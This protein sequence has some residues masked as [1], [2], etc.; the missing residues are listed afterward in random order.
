[1]RTNESSYACS[2][3]II[4]NSRFTSYS[5][6]SNKGPSKKGTASHKGHFVKSSYPYILNLQ[7][8]DI[9]S[10]METMVGPKVSFARRFLCTLERWPDHAGQ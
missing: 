2:S 1:M 9:L 8:E 10:T 3:V 4:A 6:A 5:G 7:E